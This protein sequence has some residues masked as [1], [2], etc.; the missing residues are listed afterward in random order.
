M[1]QSS[2]DWDWVE[3]ELSHALVAGA[4]PIVWGPENLWQWLPSRAAGVDARAMGS[5]KEVWESVKDEL[6]ASE[7]EEEYWGRLA[8]RRQALG[9]AEGVRAEDDVERES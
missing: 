1:A 6:G 4:V 7:G 5:G 8:W 9:V 3:P 2:L